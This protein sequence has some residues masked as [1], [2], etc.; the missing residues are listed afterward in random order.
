MHATIALITIKDMADVPT[1]R[2]D[3]GGGFFYTTADTGMVTLWH[4][5]KETDEACQLAQRHPGTSGKDAATIADD[6]L[7]G[8]K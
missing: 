7:L 8:G 3:L 2:H 1:P 4:E 5:N 6:L